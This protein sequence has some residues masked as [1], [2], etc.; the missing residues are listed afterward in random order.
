MD[1]FALS[2]GARA[3][4]AARNVV[5]STRAAAAGTFSALPGRDA[6]FRAKFLDAEA[7]EK[8]GK[9]AARVDKMLA[10]DPHGGLLEDVEDLIN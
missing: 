6:R 4:A 7:A 9:D 3:R 1:A 10:R 2:S 8:A 5:G